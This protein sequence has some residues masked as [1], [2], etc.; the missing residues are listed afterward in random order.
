MAQIL[1]AEDVK[2]LALSVIDSMDYAVVRMLIDLPDQAMVAMK[3][4]GFAATVSELVV[5]RL[6]HGKRGLL[7]VWSALLSSEVNIAYAY[8]LFPTASGAAIALRVDNIGIAIDTLR[9]HKF[10]VLSEADL[11]GES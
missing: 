2:I 7:A 4:A 9:Q 6:P 5:V 10:D 1:E 3:Q 8:P 11:A